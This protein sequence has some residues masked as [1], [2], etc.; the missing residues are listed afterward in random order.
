MKRSQAD[1]EQDDDGDAAGERK[2]ERLVQIAAKQQI[3]LRLEVNEDEPRHIEVVNRCCDGLWIGNATQRQ[4]GEPAVTI[5]D[6]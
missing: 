4:H 3:G 1:R 2:A 5:L 6:Q